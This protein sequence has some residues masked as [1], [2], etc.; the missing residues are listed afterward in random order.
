MS[1]AQRKFPVVNSYTH[2]FISFRLVEGFEKCK[3]ICVCEEGL[4]LTPTKNNFLL[5][6]NFALYFKTN[7]TVAEF[8]LFN[9][10]LR[11]S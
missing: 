11:L 9:S 3:I 4:D 8:E 2:I 1:K 6:N 7:S 5:Q 10:F